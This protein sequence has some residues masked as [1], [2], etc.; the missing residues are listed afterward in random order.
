MAVVGD[1]VGA[2]EVVGVVAAGEGEEV[3]EQPATKSMVIIR[4]AARDKPIRGN[5]LDD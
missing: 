4:I 3:L 5:L 1:G 2:A